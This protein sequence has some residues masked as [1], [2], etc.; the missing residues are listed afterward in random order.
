[1][2]RSI[3]LN[4]ETVKI[5][6]PKFKLL[7]HSASYSSLNTKHNLSFGYKIKKTVS[8]RIESILTNMQKMCSNNNK[9]F[10]KVRSS[11]IKK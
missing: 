2:G 5:Q 4:D 6:G 8:D 1:M 10:T 3:E 9:F 7:D 11:S